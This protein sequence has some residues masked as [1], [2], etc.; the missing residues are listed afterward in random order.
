MNILD[1]TR[2][3]VDQIEE[4]MA[5]MKHPKIAHTLREEDLNGDG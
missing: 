3:R 2:M 5:A 4:L 1:V